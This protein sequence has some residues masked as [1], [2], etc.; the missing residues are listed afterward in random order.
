MRQFA[1]VS[2]AL[3]CAAAGGFAFRQSEPTTPAPARIDFVKD[4]Q[5]IFNK[6]CIM[7][8]GP[9]TQMAG[10]R[11]DAKQSV[12]AKVVVPGKS[13]ES[14]LYKR[15]AGIGDAARMPM[16]GRL[17]DD[18]IVTLKA[19]IDQGAEWPDSV[20][21]TVTAAKT[22]WAFVPPE[23][24]ALPTVQ[25]A[26]WV[27]TPIDRFILA[28]LE[29]E[30]LSPS[31]EADRTTLLRR[32]SLDLTG[33][34]PTVEEVDAFVRDKSKN[35]YEKQVDRLLASPHYG[36]MWDATGWTRLTMPI[37]TAMKKISRDRFGFTEIG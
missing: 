4:V 23:R 15:V 1:S 3:A 13:T 20:G 34:P 16:G 32:L 37:R 14:A 17:A 35:A 29:R 22:H 8:H 18:Q 33:L 2:L 25:N 36:E 24:P 7:C 6:S 5:P 12:L 10:L 11:L 9:N 28:R 30:K 19:W 31:P 27:R 26:A 21:A